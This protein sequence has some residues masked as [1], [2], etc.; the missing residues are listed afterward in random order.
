MRKGKTFSHQP[1]GHAARAG[2]LRIIAGQ[3]RGRKLPVANLPGLRPTTDRV[4][5]TVFN[6][7]AA[8]IPGAH[9]LDCFSGTGALALEA[10]S[11]RADSALM[12]ERSDIAAQQL[13][14]NLSVLNTTSGTVIEADSLSYLHQSAQIPFD[15]IFLDPPFHKNFITP[16]CQLLNNQGYIH[17]DTL[18]YIERE[19]DMTQLSLPNSWTAVK[20][21]KTGQVC[22]GLWS[23]H[24]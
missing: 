3:W 12:I 23:C 13:R 15:I 11:R 5:E 21:K 19:K 16:I 18:I 14:N 4:R 17:N 10:L 2:Q 7:L 8:Y 9:I 1:S 20:E 6:W 24:G 22:Y